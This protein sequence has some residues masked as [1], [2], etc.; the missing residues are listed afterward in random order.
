MFLSPDR[1]AA[2]LV[3]HSLSFI[4][5]GS[6]SLALSINTSF[7]DAFPS[8]HLG[9]VLVAVLALQLFLHPRMLF[10]RE[11]ALYTVFV[12]YMIVQLLW[13]QDKTLAMNTI[14]PSLNV[15]MV[16][17]LYGSLV[18]FHDVRVVLK[19]MLSGVIAGAIIYTGL[20]GFPLVYPQDFSYNAMALM[21]LFGLIVTLLIACYQKSRWWLLVVGLVFGSLIVATTSIKTNLGL[22]VGAVSAFVIYFRVFRQIIRQNLVLLLVLSA[23]LAYAVASNQALIDSLQLGVNRIRLGIEILQAREDLAGYSGFEERGMW[24]IEGLRAWLQNPVFGYGVEAFRA[25]F[26]ITSH[27]TPIDLIYNSGLIGLILFYSMF[28]SLFWRLA[29]VRERN[30]AAVCAVI[31]GALVCFLF[32]TLA[33]AMNYH[34]F[35]AAFIAI[36]AGL[37]RQFQPQEKHAGT[38]RAEDP[39]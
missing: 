11:F 8:T 6:A 20:A 4:I 34:Y 22:F 25:R 9:V 16:M 23:M 1:R 31:F 37:L 13:T 36:S 10:C 27:S 30:V 39:Q 17:I 28:V 29:L 33:A 2:R 14:E 18:T 26:G 21:Y 5:A 24:A 19:G 38:S 15:V 35:L 12:V 3:G 7:Y 32:I